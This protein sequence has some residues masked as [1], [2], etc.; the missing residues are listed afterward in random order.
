MARSDAHV[1]PPHSP[2]TASLKKVC[3]FTTAAFVLFPKLLSTVRPWPA[4]TFSLVCNEPTAVWSA[5]PSWRYGRS[6]VTWA[7]FGGTGVGAGAGGGGGGGVGG[8]GGAG[9]GTGAG[10][11]AS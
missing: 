2:S 3:Q 11:G 9:V 6:T 5:T 1:S 7:T 8:G 10:S 4:R